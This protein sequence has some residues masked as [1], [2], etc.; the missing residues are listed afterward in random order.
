MATAFEIKNL[1]FRYQKKDTLVLNDISFSIKA[2]TI[3]GLLGPSGAGKSTTQ[4]ILCKLLNSYQGDI[5][6]FNRNLK[7]YNKQFYEQIGVGFEMPVHF[8]KLT[9][10][11]NMSY[12]AS[13]YQIKIDYKSLLIRVGLGEAINQQ[14]SEYSKGMKVRLNF[15]RAL[16]NN[17]DI[18]FLDEPTNGLDPSNARIIKDIIKELKQQGKTIFI[19][20]H[21]MGDVEELCDEVAFIA[22]GTLLEIASPKD[23]KRKY[24]KRQIDIE[25][26]DNNQIKTVHYPLDEI[27]TNKEFIDLVKGKTIISMH[28][29]E[30]TMENIFIKIVERKQ[31]E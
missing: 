1:S 28:T 16:L 7:S 14:V 15:V 21:L 18:I 29:A 2:G 17:P 25:Y 13:L 8:S 22:N 26:T 24:G 20:T 31:D 6:F 11:E 19:S 30:T 12:F 23:L 27:G 3:F 4:K 10:L 5:L 9:G